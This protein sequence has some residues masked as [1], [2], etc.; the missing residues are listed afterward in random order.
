[1]KSLITA[2]LGKNSVSGNGKD[3]NKKSYNILRMVA[4]AKFK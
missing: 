2:T 3:I 1:M 4:Q